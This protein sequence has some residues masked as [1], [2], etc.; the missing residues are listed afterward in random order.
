MEFAVP[1]AR[2]RTKPATP[3]LTE[4]PDDALSAAVESSV[5]DPAERSRK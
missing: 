3:P 4:V 2:T 5:D 1:M